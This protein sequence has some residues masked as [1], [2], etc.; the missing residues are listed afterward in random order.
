MCRNGTCDEDHHDVGDECCARIHEDAYEDRYCGKRNEVGGDFRVCNKCVCHQ[1]EGHIHET[2]EVGIAPLLKV[3]AAELDEVCQQYDGPHQHIE[4][5]T[6]DACEPFPH[7]EHVVLLILLHGCKY[8]IAS[9]VDNLA[10]VDDFLS[11]HHLSHIG[12]EHGEH[13]ASLLFALSFVVGEVGQDETVHG[14]A[15]DKAGRV[16]SLPGRCHKSLVCS[17]I[18]KNIPG[19]LH[20]RHLS[21]EDTYVMR[22]VLLQ[23]LVV[24][25]GHHTSCVYLLKPLFEIALQTGGGVIFFLCGEECLAECGY[26]CFCHFGVALIVGFDKAHETV[27]LARNLRFALEYGERVLGKESLAV[28]RFAELK[29]VAYKTF[30]WHERHQYGGGDD[31]TCHAIEIVFP[32]PLVL[33]VV[34]SHSRFLY[35]LCA[36]IQNFCDIDA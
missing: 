13:L 20:H 11:G 21:L 25:E 16:G 33:M 29:I 22:V 35:V 19:G 6:S 1:R 7:R 27:A 9:V 3:I 17:F 18:G 14:I 24:T 15:G 4:D 32:L 34:P 36:K 2:D 5:I 10:L 30:T 28:P 12:Y 8:G 31:D 23:T 26:L